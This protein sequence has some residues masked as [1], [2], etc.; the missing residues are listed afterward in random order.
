MERFKTGWRVLAVVF[1]FVSS[2]QAVCVA[3]QGVSLAPGVSLGSFQMEVRDDQGNVKSEVTDDGVP[4]ILARPGERYSIRVFNPLPVRA[5]V[6]LTVD[7]VNTITGQPCGVADGALWMIEPGSWITIRGWQVNGNDSRRFYFT[8]VKKSYAAWRGAKLH[9]DLASNC[10]VIGAAFF[11][12]AQELADWN[13]RQF[14]VRAAQNMAAGAPMRSEAA[15]PS[16]DRD[17]LAKKQAG[18]GMGEREIHRV[19]TVDFTA[20]A[21][22]YDPSQA[23]VLYYHFDEPKRPNPFPD[24]SFAPEMPSSRF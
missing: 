14:E 9:R 3:P 22:M 7:G 4:T 16:A 23:L 17:P 24:L 11:W 2:S 6:N 21:G 12:N 13:Q 5:A 19:R 18:T 10:G 1:L 8:P 20:T 15:A